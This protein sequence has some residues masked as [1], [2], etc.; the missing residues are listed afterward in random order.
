MQECLYAS[1][2]NDCMLSYDFDHTFECIGCN[3]CPKF[4][5]REQTNDKRS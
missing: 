4:K 1:I 2:G 5:K 3:I